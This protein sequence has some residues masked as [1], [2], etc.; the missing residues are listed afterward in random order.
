MELRLVVTV[1]RFRVPT[2]D[3]YDELEAKYWKSL[4]TSSDQVYS[5]QVGGSLTDTDQVTIVNN[6]VWVLI[7]TYIKMAK[8]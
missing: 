6:V 1:S 7:M 4:G 8:I 3:N 2:H 5:A